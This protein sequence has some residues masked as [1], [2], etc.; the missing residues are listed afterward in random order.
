MGLKFWL[1]SSLK[2][3]HNFKFGEAFLYD[4]F[5]FHKKF[6]LLEVT[7]LLPP[8]EL[9]P[10]GIHNLNRNWQPSLSR[11]RASTALFIKNFFFWWPPDFSELRPPNNT[12][13][14]Y[15]TFWQVLK[16]LPT[17]PFPFH[18]E[19]LLLMVAPLFSN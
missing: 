19:S 10:K 13:K 1:W 12:P 3:K 8:L 5:S 16:N 15:T 14:E 9:S 17:G 4:I 11:I 2:D 18:K 7:P 6:L